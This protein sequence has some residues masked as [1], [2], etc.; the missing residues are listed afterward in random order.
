MKRPRPRVAYAAIALAFAL[1]AAAALVAAGR[2][3]RDTAS[4]S[5][6]V[7]QQ[8]TEAP[9]LS[10]GTP[11]EL[12]NFGDEVLTTERTNVYLGAVD[13]SRA[14]FSIEVTA[15]RWAAVSDLYLELSYRGNF[16]RRGVLH[17]RS[18]MQSLIDGEWQR[19]YFSRSDFWN[20]AP[21]AIDWT[22]IS[23]VRI[24]PN[25]RAD[26]GLRIGPLRAVAST[27][28]AVVSVVFDDGYA[29]AAAVAAP[30]LSAKGMR[31]AVYLI[32][33]TSAPRY[34]AASQIAALQA[35]GWEI[36]G[37]TDPPLAGVARP[38]LESQ[39]GAAAANAQRFRTAS[40]RPGFAYALG[41][42][43]AAVRGE[44]ED[45]YLYARG[46][47]PFGQSAD[48]AD[49]FNLNA[50]QPG[51]S[52]TIDDVR[53]WIDAAIAHDEWLIL[54]FHR[55][56]GKHGLPEDVDPA[57]LAAT[58]DYLVARGVAVK[59]PSEVLLNRS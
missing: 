20:T 5:A 3:E 39:L 18:G 17:L 42:V 11:V 10:V 41:S 8:T 28:P 54:A 46:T 53:Q 1:I 59:T 22:R 26:A 24:V 40:D 27:S 58:V 43:D 57:L 34:L 31:G 9:R 44:A 50:R 32:P 48:V 23:A 6:G 55:V 14:V 56:D 13:L 4:D 16:A 7:Q 25:A 12:A 15:A 35:A 36:G 52:T 19:Y 29:S 37:H 2:H 21:G 45:Y 30:L 33:D 47:S 38:T 51:A 49:R